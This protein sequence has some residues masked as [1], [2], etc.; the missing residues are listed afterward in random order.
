MFFNRL[1]HRDTRKSCHRIASYRHHHQVENAI[2]RYTV[3][4]DRSSTEITAAN[5]TGTTESVAEQARRRRGSWRA[6]AGRGRVGRTAV[7]VFASRCPMF[8]KG[9]VSVNRV[10][11]SFC[12]CNCSTQS[13]TMVYVSVLK[14]AS[15]RCL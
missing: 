2:K 4:D 7:A 3:D 14:G 11:G 13:D 15:K 12:G 9:G 8:T 6:L 10:A 1:K 5:Q